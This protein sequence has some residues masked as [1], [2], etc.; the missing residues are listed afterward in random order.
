LRK[1]TA[2]SQETFR[3]CGQANIDYGTINKAKLEASMVVAWTI[4]EP[5][6][7][8]KPSGG[9]CMM[10]RSHKASRIAFISVGQLS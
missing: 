1:T 3:D 7:V 2:A 8:D 9:A 5:L 6:G 4:L 10:T